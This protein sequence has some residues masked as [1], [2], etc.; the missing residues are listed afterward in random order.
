MA[1]HIKPAPL[2][3]VIGDRGTFKTDNEWLKT[4]EEV[5]E[6]L[7]KHKQVALQVRIKGSNS[8]SRF[9]RMQLARV[10]LDSAIQS[11]LR[12][13]LN[14]TLTQAE[15]LNFPGVHLKEELLCKAL[16]NPKNIEI[17]TSTHS[18]ES[19]EQSQ[20]LGAAFCVFGP[21]Y[22]PKSKNAKPVGIGAL[23]D[24]IAK[25]NIDVLALGGITSEK[26]QPC[27]RAGAKGIA[28]ISSVMRSKNPQKSIQNLLHAARPE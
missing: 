28:C 25:T 5:A 4:L 8:I 20:M 13:F 14:G 23:Q 18:L 1:I 21:V 12:V 3:Y 22:V 19:V 24:V 26:V 6:A 9:R 27:L 11:G 10:K 2:L 7:L 15:R 16:S 17:A